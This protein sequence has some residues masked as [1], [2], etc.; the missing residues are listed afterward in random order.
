M[1]LQ[2]P[3]TISLEDAL[4]RNS[5]DIVEKLTSKLLEN[6]YFQETDANK[7][8]LTSWAKLSPAGAS[9]LKPGNAIVQSMQPCTPN[10]SPP[11]VSS[12]AL[13]S[14]QEETS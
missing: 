5:D 10:V 12:R 11:P 2:T 8:L 7:A 9:A 4:Y 6:K 1:K 13:Y 14:I 3:E